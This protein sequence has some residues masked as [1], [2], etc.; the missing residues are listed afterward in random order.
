MNKQSHRPGRYLYALC[1]AALVGLAPMIF[2][3]VVDPFNMNR[4]V[5]L[6]L[7]KREISVKAHY[8]L[9]KMIEYPRI[10]ARTVILGD[11]RARALQDRYFK[12]LGYKDVYNFAYGGATV[13]EIHDTF[14]YLVANADVDTLIVGLP[15]RSM[16]ARHKN[17]L[18]RVPEAISMA[19]DPVAYY[20][21]WFVAKIGWSLLED[22]YPRLVDTLT[23]SLIGSAEASEF[24]H[25]GSISLEALLNPEM[26]E[27]C[28]LPAASRSLR[29]SGRYRHYGLGLGHWAHLWP[30]IDIE[31]SLPG[32]FAKQVGTNGAADWRRFEQSEAL[33]QKLVE[34]AE[35]CAENGVELIFV[36]PPTIPEMQKRIVDFGLSA[37]NQ[38]FRERLSGLAPVVDLDFDNA[39]T[40][41]IDN[42]TDAYHFD[43]GA[44]RQIVGEIVQLIDDGAPASRARKR[45]KTVLCPVSDAESTLEFSDDNVSLAEGQACR[46]WRRK[47]V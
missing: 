47:D 20:T 12:E 11:S 34:M 18:N 41:D 9:Y 22:R 14:R 38:R 40:R 16:D 31:R 30:E 27:E 3:I 37:A 29:P 4:M 43:A 44:A 35:W 33:W 19:T 25:P 45:R 39:F 1:A 2:N 10:N 7:D 36:V 46:I 13:F 28:R 21:S 23:P 32:G 42:F 15:L 26:C 24:D 17:G 5:E 6:D 8:P